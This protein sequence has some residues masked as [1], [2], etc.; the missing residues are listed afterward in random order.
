MPRRTLQATLPSRINS[1][2]WSP[3]GCKIASGSDLSINIWDGSTFAPI[4]ASKVEGRVLSVAFTPDSNQLVSGGGRVQ[5]WDVQGM[6]HLRNYEGHGGIVYEVAVSPD[7]GILASGSEDGTIFLWRLDTAECIQVL[8]GHASGVRA[9]AFSFAGRRL[10]SG[11]VDN[12]IAIW[13]LQSYSCI[14]TLTNHSRC[15]TSLSY[16]ADGCMLASGSVDDTICIYNAT[17]YARLRTIR[18]D[19]DW[20][21]SVRFTPDS[22][23]LLFGC[24]NS[25]IYAHGEFQVWE[26]HTNGVTSVAVSPDG[27]CIVSGSND[28]TVR[29]W[30]LPPAKGIVSD[31]SELSYHLFILYLAPPAAPGLPSGINLMPEV[32][33]N[34][35]I[36]ITSQL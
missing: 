4:A 25:L 2:A 29:I 18:G 34:V 23:T 7:G 21:L 11:S 6:S 27:A 35:Q 14:K 28:Q 16:S 33:T 26:G 30:S 36:L 9:V 32:F 24:G 13:D 31:V 8:G 15:V 19:Y 1:V 10:A 22:R 20:V 5:L 12:T 3:D 17:T